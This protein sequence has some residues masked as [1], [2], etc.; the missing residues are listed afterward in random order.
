MIKKIL[1][2][3]DGSAT[4]RKAVDYAMDVAKGLGSEVIILSVI[5]EALMRS[6][7]NLVALDPMDISEPIEERMKKAAE[8]N[9]KEAKNLF[10]ERGIP[11][12]ISIRSGHPAEE[13]V[14]EADTVKAD[15]IIMGSHGKTSLSIIGGVAF[16]VIHRD[17]GI[18]VLVV[19][20]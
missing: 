7:M 6:Y 15:M 14:S 9:A 10:K 4:S 13:I 16:G 11:A 1:L 12:Q 3:V 20:K 2:A 18:P 19:R 5:D 17:T 8:A